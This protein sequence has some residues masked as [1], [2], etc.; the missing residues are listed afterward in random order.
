MYIQMR[1]NCEFYAG[2]SLQTSYKILE[3]SSRLNCPRYQLVWLTTKNRRGRTISEF[4]T[5]R[6]RGI[7]R[8]HVGRHSD[9]GKGLGGR[10]YPEARWF[11]GTDG[12]SHE[13]HVSYEFQN[14]VW[15]NLP[16]S[17]RIR[18][19]EERK[20][21]NENRKHF[22]Q[23]ISTNEGNTLSI[24]SDVSNFTANTDS[25]MGVRNEQ[26]SLKSRTGTIPNTWLLQR[27]R[28]TLHL[29]TNI[30]THSI[31]I[32]VSRRIKATHKQGNVELPLLDV[33][34]ENETDTNADTCWLGK[35]FTIISHTSRTGYVY[36]YDSSYSPI[37]NVLIVTSV[38]AW[39]DS[40]GVTYILIIHEVLYYGMQL[41]HS[42]INSNQIRANGIDVHDN[43]F[44]TP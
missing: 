25:I 4:N 30:I 32:L 10:E 6:G 20:K 14:L 39:N 12:K 33:K 1:W 26:A 28:E 27:L 37:Q 3:H 29:S 23:K 2:K 43:P 9:R 13:I 18:I 17:E 22:T 7:G 5:V 40:T 8:S 34:T 21:F 44:N 35:N 19:F 41:D 15:Q 38:T 24:S 36:P 42:L 11:T 16:Y 31:S